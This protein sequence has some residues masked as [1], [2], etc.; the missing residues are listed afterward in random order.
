MAPG[1][2]HYSWTLIAAAVAVLAFLLY[3][4]GRRLIGHQRFHQRRLVI[5]VVLFGV[6]TVLLLVSF[7]GR[8]APGLAYASAA[9]G[10]AIGLLVALVALR[11]TQMGRDENGVWYVPNLYLGMG[12]VSLLVARFIYEYFVIFPQ[13]RKQIQAA[14]AHGG[15]GVHPA[16]F[17]PQPV[18]HGVLFLVLG[19]YVTYYLGILIRARREGHL[20]APDAGSDGESK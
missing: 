13:V 18:L 10:F 8:P 14:A 19:Y 7:T 12:L 3:R 6:V 20:L 5:R 9:A 15:A 2:G 16:V 11:F 4:R 1:S 17:T